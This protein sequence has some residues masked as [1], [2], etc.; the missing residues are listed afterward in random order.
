M[1]LTE[2][3]YIVAVS[4]KNHFGKAAQACFVSQPTLSIAIKKLE[5]ELGVRLFERSSKNEIRITEIGQ[6]VINQAYIVLQ[7]AQMLSEIAQQG[8]DPLSGPFR[9]GV[10]YTIGPYLLPSLIPVLTKNVPN[11]KLIIEEN[12]TANLFQSL[13][14]GA[15]DAIIISYPFEEP[16]IET[17]PLYEEPFIVALPRNHEWKDRDAISPEDLAS[18]DLMLLGAGHCFR[19]Q[20]IKACPNCMSGNSELTRTLEGGSLETIRHMVAAGTGI[21]VLPRTSIMHSQKIESMIDIKPFKSPSP[22]RTVAIAWRK[23]YPRKEAIA[24]IRDT[25]QACSL[26]GVKIIH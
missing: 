4:Q 25:I 12:F 16:G 13:K 24:T 2:L 8:K 9:L 15:L 14:Q 1:T 22:N 19:D 6:Q 23:H 26:N 5:E 21:T 20:V 11:L 17:A 7:E 10:I 3:R 18:Q